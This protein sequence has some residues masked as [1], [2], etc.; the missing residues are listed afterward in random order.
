MLGADPLAAPFVKDRRA[1][2][3]RGAWRAIHEFV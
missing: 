1:A 2:H 3:R